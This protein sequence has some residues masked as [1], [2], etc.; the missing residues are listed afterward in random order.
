[1]EYMLAHGNAPGPTQRPALTGSLAAAVAEIPAA[2]ILWKAGSLAAI[3]AALGTSPRGALALHSAA[4]VL[5]GAA[6]GRI[7][8]RA[9]NDPRGGWLFGLGWGYVIWMLAVGPL[10][11]V[12][13]S[14]VATGAAALGLL[15]GHLV[16]GLGLGLLVPPVHRA[17]RHDLRRATGPGARAP[18]GTFGVRRA[19]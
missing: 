6:Y 18:R 7:F 19:R 15:G 8:S 2:A 13:G 17:L 11:W 10:A 3:A 5:A 1:M 14:P 16:L 12:R 4:M 9:A